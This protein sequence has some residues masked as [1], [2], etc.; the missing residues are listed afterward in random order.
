M[1]GRVDVNN[2]E[3]VADLEAALLW[4]LGV[5][6]ATPGDPL[7]P[8]LRGACIDRIELAL[9]ESVEGSRPAPDLRGLRR[10]NS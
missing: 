1:G 8:E 6:E 4:C 2:D 10:N 5:L 3:R 7:I 9:G